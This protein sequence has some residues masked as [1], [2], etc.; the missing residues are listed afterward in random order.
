V[1]TEK[2][3]KAAGPKGHFLAPGVQVR[4]ERNGL[5]FYSR[6]GPR[7]YFLPCGQKLDPGYF[8]SGQTLEQWLGQDETQP[9]REKQLESLGQALRQLV[10]KGVLGDHQ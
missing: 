8:A 1:S 5:L 6:Q 4:S 10:E 3:G 9:G 7:L 2:R